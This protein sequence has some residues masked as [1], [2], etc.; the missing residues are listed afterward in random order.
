MQDVVSNLTLCIRQRSLATVQNDHLHGALPRDLFHTG[1]LLVLGCM[2][3]LATESDQPLVENLHLLTV[4][5]ATCFGPMN[6]PPIVSSYICGI[7]P[8]FPQ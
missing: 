1:L 5:L 7:C 3:H 8:E 6:L 2:I 4:L